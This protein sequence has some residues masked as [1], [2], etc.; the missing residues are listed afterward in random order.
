MSVEI[1]KSQQ[2]PTVPLPEFKQPA[3]NIGQEILYYDDYDSANPPRPGWVT[4]VSDNSVNVSVIVDGAQNLLPR[5]GCRHI[6]DPNRE[7]MVRVISQGDGG[8]WDFAKP[9]PS[10]IYA[11]ALARI[12][13]LEEIVAD[14]M[15]A[16][17]KKS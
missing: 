8:L 6:N 7:L 12:A 5:N 17:S 4:A 11:D 15:K 10:P 1:P 3:V 14:L 13:K 16:T 2:R 9:K